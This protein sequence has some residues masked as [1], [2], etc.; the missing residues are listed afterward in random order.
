MVSLDPAMAATWALYSPAAFTTTWAEKTAS[1][2]VTWYPPEAGATAVTGWFRKKATPLATAFSARATVYRK[3]SQIPV[4]GEK[5]PP[6][7]PTWGELGLSRARSRSSSPRR[8][9]ASPGLSGGGGWPGRFRQRPPGFF[10][11]SERA[12]PASRHRGGKALIP[13]HAELGHQA[14]GRLLPAA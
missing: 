6:M 14:P 12:R 3:G 13:R 9:L 7:P 1:P 2:A 5:N 11:F 8:L 10:R 4:S